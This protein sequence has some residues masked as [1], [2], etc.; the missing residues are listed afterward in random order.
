ME[1]EKHAIS[2]DKNDDKLKIS[3]KTDLHSMGPEP[4]E[5]AR[6]DSDG[7]EAKSFKPSGGGSR[8]TVSSEERTS[9]LH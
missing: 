2:G 5:G 8:G 7:D 4:P 6:G 3:H 1:K 9:P